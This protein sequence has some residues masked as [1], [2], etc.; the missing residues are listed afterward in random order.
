VPARAPR[1]PIDI[2]LVLSNTDETFS[3]KALLV[4]SAEESI[5]IIIEKVTSSLFLRTG[6][7]LGDS[8]SAAV[9]NITLPFIR[10]SSPR[11]RTLRP[12]PIA[13]NNQQSQQLA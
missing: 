8:L 9:A 12:S 2:L 5:I 11:I 6:E 10:L 1:I 13:Q 4:Q 3:L 7:S